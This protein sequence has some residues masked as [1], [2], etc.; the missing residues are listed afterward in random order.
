MSSDPTPA[1]APVL[2]SGAD[3]HGSGFITFY[4]RDGFVKIEAADVLLTE[5]SVELR[6]LADA[7]T[8]AADKLDQQAAQSLPSP[9]KAH[10]G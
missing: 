9:A 3:G 7:A 5:S 4:E 1:S 2:L 8:W 6:A 10:R